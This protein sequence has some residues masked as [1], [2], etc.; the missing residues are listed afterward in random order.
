VI[1]ARVSE[2]TAAEIR[3]CALDAWHA[4]GCTD[5]ARVDFRVDA[6][7]TPYVLELNPNPDIAPD[8]GF[9]AALEAARIPYEAFV[10]GVVRNA[11][12][13]LPVHGDATGRSAP[14]PGLRPER[15]PEGGANIRWSQ[16]SERDAILGLVEG[17]GRFRK[18]EMDIAQEVLDDA[19][20]A[21]PQGHYQ[22]YTAHA[23]GRPT[24][25][26]CYGPTP[27]TVGTVDI[28]WLVVDSA[29]QG[30]GIG[31]ALLRHVEELI[32]AAGAR[33]AVVET[34]TRGDYEQARRFYERHGYEMRANVR[35]FYAAG[36][37]KCIYCK[38]FDGPPASGA[39]ANR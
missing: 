10:D 14:G 2:E 3:R 12:S 11:L 29:A 39:S 36:D 27:C 25:W 23:N 33:L 24:A 13:R 1:P 6:A 20:R 8:A 38:P 26:A 15:L 30:R 37:G 17:T 21:G 34:S 5:Y 4:V 7:G 32:R 18:E 28:Y 19:L 9:A 16:R 31:S 35:D 22:S